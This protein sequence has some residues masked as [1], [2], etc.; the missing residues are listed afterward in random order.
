MVQEE[1][2]AEAEQRRALQEELL[3]AKGAVRVLCRV[4]P[5]LPGEG[6]AA[7]AAVQCLPGLGEIDVFAGRCGPALL[8]ASRYGGVGLIGEPALAVTDG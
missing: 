4:R 2:V 8:C 5:P 6:A 1:R 3:E 7:P